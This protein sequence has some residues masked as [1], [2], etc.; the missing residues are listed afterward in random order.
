MR[1]DEI[2]QLLR[3]RWWKDL[4]IDYRI[5]DELAANN[6]RRKPATFVREMSG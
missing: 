1:Y 3:T 5:V 4:K 6:R 2:T